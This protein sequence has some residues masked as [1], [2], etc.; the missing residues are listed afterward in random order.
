MLCVWSFD[1]LFVSLRV[2]VLCLSP[3]ECVLVRLLVCL[4]AGF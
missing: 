3:F 4:L 1:C 2:R